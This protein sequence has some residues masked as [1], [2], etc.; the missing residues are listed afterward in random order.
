MSDTKQSVAAIQSAVPAVAARQPSP[1]AH[2]DFPAH[3]LQLA[4]E[5]MGNRAVGN[6]VQA[7]LKVNTPGDAYEQEADRVAD[8]VMRMPEPAVQRK[9]AACESG[10]ASCPEC[11]KEEEEP[12]VQ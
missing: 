3:R 6:W 8:Q 5:A 4:H 9:C 1:E 11:A 10:G 7:Q 2:M 12:H